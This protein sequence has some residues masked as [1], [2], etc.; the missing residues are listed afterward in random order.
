MPPRWRYCDY[1][2]GRVL[3]AIEESGELDNTLVIYIQGDNGASAEGGPQ[4]LLNEMSFFN[5]MPEDFKEVLRRMD[6]L[7]GPTTFNHY[8]IGWAHAMDTPFQW[9]KQI[10]SHFGGTRN[11]MVDLLAGAHQGQGRHPHAVP[12]CHRHRADDPRSGRRASA[13]DAQRRA[14]EADRRRQHGLHLRRCEGGLDATARS[15]SRCSAIAPSTTTAGSP[16]RRR[17]AAVGR[18]Q[19]ASTSMT[20]SGSSTT[21]EG[22]SARPMISPPR[23]RQSC[24][25][26]RNLFW[27]EAAKYNVLPLDNSKIERMDVDNRP[28]LTRGR[29]SSPTIPGMT[30]IPEGSAP[31][32]RTSRSRSP[33]R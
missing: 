18:R 29:A 16:R 25:S 17:R 5:G 7:G 1:Q 4:G 8:P 9:T 13:D 24:G 26:C 27:I 11:G 28:S 3:E 14:A 19:D 10:A 32:S 23:S 12:P 2:M 33:P 22:L 6:E 20:T 21:T 30:R 15:I 31:T